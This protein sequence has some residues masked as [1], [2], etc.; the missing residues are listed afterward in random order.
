MSTFFFNVLNWETTIVTTKLGLI[1]IRK[2][3]SKILGFLLFKTS[4]LWPH[5]ASWKKVN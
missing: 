5:V 3:R 2:K 4:G 1:Q